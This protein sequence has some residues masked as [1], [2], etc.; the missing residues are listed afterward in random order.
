M[1]W[2]ADEREAAINHCTNPNEQCCTCKHA[3]PKDYMVYECQKWC[4]DVE[5]DEVCPK[6]EVKIQESDCE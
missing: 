3:K 6:F 4:A 1:K 5:Y 2:T